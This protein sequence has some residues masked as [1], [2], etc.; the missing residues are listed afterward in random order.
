[1][2]AI[3]FSMHCSLPVSEAN[4]LIAEARREYPKVL[5]YFWISEAR[6]ALAPNRERD[7]EYGF[8]PKSC[9]LVQ[10]NQERSELIR[11]VPK[12]FYKVFGND[13]LLVRD[14]NYELIPPT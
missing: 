5:G 14:L 6:E 12:I 11:L 9:F 3:F 1:M 8:E 7:L 10:W 2:M 13:N 4:Q